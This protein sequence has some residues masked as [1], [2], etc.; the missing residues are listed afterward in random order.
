MAIAAVDDVIAVFAGK[1]IVPSP[2]ISVVGA[3]AAVEAVIAV[4]AFRVVIARSG[5]EKSL[6]SPP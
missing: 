5:L 1:D 6:P 4:A 2:P 3:G